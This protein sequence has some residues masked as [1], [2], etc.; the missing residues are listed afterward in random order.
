MSDMCNKIFPIIMAG[1]SGT[2]L[3]PLSRN[4]RPK[5]FLNFFGKSTLLQ[6]AINRVQSIS[7]NAPTIVCNEE[8]RFL[9]AEQIRETSVKECSLILEPV[10][11]NT[12]PTVALGALY[13]QK[14]RGNGLILV[15]A[16]DHLIKNNDEFN[17]AVKRA[18]PLA[19][20][21][22]IV[23][24]GIKPSSAETGYGYIKAGGKV[25]SGFNVDKF[26]EKPNKETATK[27][28]ESSDYLWNSGIFLMRVETYLSALKEHAPSILESCKD[29]ID[30]AFH[31]LDFVRVDRD[32]FKN[33]PSES[34]DY[35]VIEK[36]SN[37]VVVPMDAGW[38][39]VGSWSSLWEV[40]EK[41]DDD[42]SSKGD[43]IL[44]DSSKNLIYSNH[45]LVAVAG[46]KN[47]IVVETKD[48]VLVCHKNSSQDIKR[49][50]ENLKECKRIEYIDHR[51]VYRPWGKYD[52][53]DTDERYKVKR[54][55]VNPGQKL[56]VQMHYHRSE[57]WIIVSGTAHVGIGKQ[58]KILTE[59]QSIYIPLG[60]K[61]YLSNPGKIPL[62]L[63]EVQSGTY[64]EEDDI[65]RFDDIYG[66]S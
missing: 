41:D 12:A 48:A 29:A 66:R 16:A 26:V 5:Q 53:I 42:N 54:I 44:E 45:R 33:C 40:S 17:A 55:T 30:R 25:G 62:E 20:D 28:L 18:I 10:G 64:L 19:E 65:V 35:A 8:H 47:L 57:H 24:F 9:A 51:E 59:N 43:V 4:A 36:V 14:K 6:D 63:I 58:E 60:E 1:G 2:R 11:K 56:S 46:V 32:L 15:L 39:D 13:T 21:G 31:D 37:I 22:A 27:Y 49:I 50:V 3:W 7:C 61:H 38:S 23:T 52:S 34:I